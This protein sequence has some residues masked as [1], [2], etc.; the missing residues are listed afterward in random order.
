MQ[1]LHF[2]RAEFGQSDTFGPADPVEIV[3]TFTK[4]AGGQSTYSSNATE[5]SPSV[6]CYW[7]AGGRDRDLP[8]LMLEK[9]QTGSPRQQRLGLAPGLRVGPAER[10]WFPNARCAS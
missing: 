10:R 3:K 5:M 1:D 8:D 9:P 2:P 4:T 6:Q 7:K